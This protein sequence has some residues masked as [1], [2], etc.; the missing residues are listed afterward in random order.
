M[1]KA[2]DIIVFG[3]TGYSGKLVLKYLLEKNEHTRIRL[4]I[5]GRTPSKLQ[6]ILK[7]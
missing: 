6:D 4:G 2:F 7:G 5:A 1:S 3:A